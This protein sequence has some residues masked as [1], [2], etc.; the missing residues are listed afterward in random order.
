MWYESS[1][2]QQDIVVSIKIP[3]DAA[4]SDV[5]LG[6]SGV[7]VWKAQFRGVNPGFL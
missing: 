5:D 2:K 7:F 6:F 4:A 3:P 1:I